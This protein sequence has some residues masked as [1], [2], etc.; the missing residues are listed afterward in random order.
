MIVS[1][2]IIQLLTLHLSRIVR[3]FVS[4]RLNREGIDEVQR[5]SRKDMNIG[6]YG[7]TS[8]LYWPVG[9]H[10]K[11]D[12]EPVENV[13]LF[14]DLRVVLAQLFRIRCSTRTV[15]SMEVVARDQAH[16]VAGAS[17]ED[18]HSR[19]D[20]GRSIARPSLRGC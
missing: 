11:I 8:Y 3:A 5:M 18:W 7:P 9:E 16:T 12:R 10:M 6:K 1:L 13:G 17:R 2:L 19:N 15:W 14:L 4:G 20:T